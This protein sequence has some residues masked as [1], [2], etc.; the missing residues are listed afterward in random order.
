MQRD[1][2]KTIGCGTALLVSFCGFHEAEHEALEPKRPMSSLPKWLSLRS[3]TR[4]G[5]ASTGARRDLHRHC[6]RCSLH[7]AYQFNTFLWKICLYD[8]RRVCA[9]CC[10]CYP[11][12][13]ILISAVRRG[14]SQTKLDPNARMTMTARNFHPSIALMARYRASD[15]RT[16]S[17]R[18]LDEK[19]SCFKSD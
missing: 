10:R 14:P 19:K 16:R 13:T 18:D 7:A 15:C 1:A 6:V 5:S 3:H 12:H 9:V 17:G 8:L 11:Y 4:S 2:W